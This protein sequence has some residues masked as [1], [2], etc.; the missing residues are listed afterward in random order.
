MDMFSRGNQWSSSLGGILQLQN[1]IKSLLQQEEALYTATFMVS[2]LLNITFS[3][4]SASF[5]KIH[6]VEDFCLYVIGASLLSKLQ[7]EQTLRNLGDL[8]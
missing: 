6:E 2:T 3:S 4:S 1:Q 8:V 7:R 5:T